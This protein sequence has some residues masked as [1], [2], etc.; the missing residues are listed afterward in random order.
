MTDRNSLPLTAFSWGY[1]GWGNATPLLVEGV[2]AAEARSG[3]EP[4]L[5]VDVRFSRSVRA[6]GFNGNAFGV[7]VGTKRY[8]WM[9]TLGNKQIGQHDGPRM[10]IAEPDAA[11]ELLEHLRAA[12]RDRRRV[13]FFCSC[14]HACDDH[15]TH[16]H[17]TE[18]ARLLH[19]AAAERGVP[20]ETV[21]WPGGLPQSVAVKTIPVLL[22]AIARG[23]VTLPLEGPFNLAQVAGL[24]WG[25]VVRAHHGEQSVAFVSGPAKFTGGSWCLPVLKTFANAA[26]DGDD[27][28]RWGAELRA[29]R[30]LESLGTAMRVD[31]GGVAP[32]C[33][34]TI[35]HVD[36]LRAIA[37]GSGRGS[38]TEGRA[39]ESAAK[40]LDQARANGRRLPI[41]FADAADCSRL[42]YS[43]TLARIETSGNGTR[44]TFEGLKALRGAHTPQE[45]TLVSTGRKIAP[46]FIRPYAICMTPGFLRT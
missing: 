12:A 31:E 3:F 40:Q 28:E 36:K 34:Y 21:E 25:S 4:P 5:F 41:V 18:V 20:L 30:M 2:D 44:Y 45:L 1:W 32:T 11:S 33:V 46:G 9:R 14:E 6:V 17:R 16:C 24:P 27:A 37:A 42:L 7:L 26:A 35:A 19:A 13:L 10:A 38:L 8:V 43:A 29:R 22:R 15:G 39:W 23:R